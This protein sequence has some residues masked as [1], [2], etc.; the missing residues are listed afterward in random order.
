MAA[1][2]RA[3]W[4]DLIDRV[5]DV[6]I[7]CSV[8]ATPLEP[9]AANHVWAKSDIREVQDRLKQVCSEN[10][11]TEPIPNLWL[12]SILDEIEAAIERG[13]CEGDCKILYAVLFHCQFS[14]DVEQ[15][16][17][18]TERENSETNVLV[19]GCVL[20]DFLS[21]PEVTELIESLAD[22]RLTTESFIAANPTFFT[23]T[24]SNGS[25]DNKTITDSGYTMFCEPGQTCDGE[26]PDITWEA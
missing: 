10:T 13:C 21:D 9:V 6:A 8:E 17:G 5:N 22:A 11:F 23:G 3:E 19:T 20:S 25:L 24:V 2:S 12:Q 14:Y 1:Y 18:G 7:A 4:N 15:P 16:D 26:T